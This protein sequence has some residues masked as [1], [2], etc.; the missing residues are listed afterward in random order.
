V[1]AI[2]PTS[3]S[4]QGAS[5]VYN[6]VN[7]IQ[8]FGTG[9]YTFTPRSVTDDDCYVTASSATQLLVYGGFVQS[10]FDDNVQGTIP[11]GHSVQTDPIQ[12]VP[13]YFA[14]AVSRITLTL[15]RTT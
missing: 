14:F 15:N 2:N 11:D 1:I 10:Q 7:L 9:A 4:A 8:N 12:N 13:S 5:H 3:D 6:Y